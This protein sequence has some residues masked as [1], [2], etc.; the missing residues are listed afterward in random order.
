MLPFTFLAVIYVLCVVGVAY[1]G[2]NTLA[3][4]IGT[5]L[6]ALFFTPLLAFIALVV[7]A[8]PAARTRGA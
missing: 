7:F 5:G 1:L 6:F 2:R 8:R 4:P 3:G